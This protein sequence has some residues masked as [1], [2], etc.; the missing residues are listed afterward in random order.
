MTDITTLR[1]ALQE[2]VDRDCRVFDRT[3]EITFESHQQAMR[4][5]RAAR[6]AYRAA[7]APAPM[8]AAATDVLAERRRSTTSS[9]MR[10]RTTGRGED[11]NRFH[12]HPKEQS[13][14]GKFVIVRTYSAGVH[15][16]T[17]AAHAGTEVQLTGARRI[18]YWKGA[19]TLHEI[20]LRGVDKKG[21]KVS[22]PV[23]SILLTEAIEIIPA[24]A[25]AAE[26]LGSVVW[27]R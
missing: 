2:L 26:N 6:E 25:E 3:L 12:H 8:T 15:A 4:A 9:A 16:G 5:L 20:A 27:A 19:N 23:Q 22:E 14:I 11:V 13:M 1:D 24:T 21:S 10:G 18:W 7:E 17:L